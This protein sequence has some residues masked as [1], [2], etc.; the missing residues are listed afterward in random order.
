MRCR[1]RARTILDIATA[2]L[3]SALKLQ[4]E[5]ELIGESRDVNDDTVPSIEHHSQNQHHEGVIFLVRVLVESLCQVA[6]LDR[7][8][9]K[10]VAIGWKDLPGR[11]GLRLCLHAMRNIQ[12]F[13]P[14][15]AM[16][17]LLSVSDIDFW[18]IRREI[19]LLLKDRAGTASPTLVN[20]VEK[21][22]R[23]SS[24]AYFDR[25]TI[26]PGEADWRSHARDAAVWLRLNMLQDAD[27]LS[28]IGGVELSAIKE[29]RDY[30][31]RAVED[32]NF[33]G[34]YSYGVH[35]VVGNPE[36]IAEAAEDDRL[37]VAKELIRSPKLDLQQGWSAYCRSD[38]QGAFDSLCN[39]DPTPENG[40]LWN[41]FLL[42]LALFDAENKAVRDELAMRALDHLESFSLDALKPMASGLA[43]L[44]F[45]I[46][47]QEIVNLENWLDRLWQAISDQP[48]KALDLTSDLYEQAVNSN[49]GKLTE[50]LLFGLQ[51]KRQESAASREPLLKLAIRICGYDGSVG[52]LARAVLTVNVA[53]LLAIDRQCVVDTL[54]PCISARDHEGGALRAVMLKHGSITPSISHVLGEAIFKGVVESQEDGH[55]AAVVASK[56]IRPAMAEVRSGNQNLWGLNASQVTDVL[57]QASQ[58]IRCG[59][60]EVLAGWLAA[61]D[62][63]AEKAWKTTFGPFFHRVWPKELVFRDGSL[64]PRFVELAVKAGNAFPEALE[65]LRPYI[66]PYNPDAQ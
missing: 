49:V 46:R 61:D 40:V 11:I 4:G 33:F 15:E 65:Q 53:F 52:Q 20:R 26:E 63:G 13:D 9:A 19:A 17:N 57:R 50:T 35:Q 12:L 2:E 64:A 39:G 25:Y 30:L 58:A 42:G 18:E 43:Y 29:R 16:S 55:A 54:A 56:I 48:E 5:L 59:A 6:T 32:R 38:P 62:S 51:I 60:L 1:D 31:N 8:Y 34:S 45:S 23:H 41:N 3:R 7:E 27:V 37:R 66:V 14:D 47:R 22:I 24:D 36:P 21:R 28:E 44:M 10:G